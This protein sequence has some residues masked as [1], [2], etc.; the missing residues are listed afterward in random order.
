VIPVSPRVEASASLGT[1]E[2]LRILLVDD[3]ENDVLRV[4]GMLQDITG[5][6][7]DLRWLASH[8]EASAA[9]GLKEHD[10][11]F[12]DYPMGRGAG[13][14]LLREAVET[15]GDVPVIVLA[16]H[17]DDELVVAATEAGATACLLKERLDPKQLERTVRH[18][19]AR[20]RSGDRFPDPATRDSLTGLLNRL[21]LNDR[22]ARA[23]TYAARFGHRLA[24]LFLDLDNF[25][26]VNDAHGREA[27][28][29]LLQHVAKRLSRCVRLTDS[30]ARQAE[31]D[32][33]MG[34][35]G[36]DEFIL[37]LTNIDQIE[38]V[39]MV[40]NR[41]LREIGKVVSDLTPPVETSASIG[42]SIYPDHGEEAQAL[43]DCADTALFHAKADGKG[44]YRLY[45]PE[46]VEHTR[47]RLGLR[48]AL[49]Q[50]ELTLGY[51]PA[52]TLNER[53]LIALE[54]LPTW[55]HSQQGVIE[56][57]RLRCLAAQT[58]LVNVLDSWVLR[59][60][61]DQARRWIAAGLAPVPLVAPLDAQSLSPGPVRELRSAIEE[62]GTRSLQVAVAARLLDRPGGPY[63]PELLA[64]LRVGLVLDDFGSGPFA[65][66]TLVQLPLKMIWVSP[67]LVED[68]TS[69]AEDRS[70]IRGAVALAHA[71]GCQVVARGVETDAQLN[72]MLELGCDGGQG[73]LLGPPLTADEAAARLRR[74][75]DG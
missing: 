24:V 41:I 48:R 26:Q 7:V 31:F 9:F 28:D 14:E 61:A 56:S 38:G 6:Q 21:H 75:S 39:V 51:L 47:D 64:E 33:T 45:Q 74:A 16:D 19:L 55:A 58:G 10:L 42:I 43:I 71:L 36:G 1:M 4:R 59:A 67:R 22:L 35:L 37:L 52:V 63:L 2:T 17:A 15:G 20:K 69:S 13:L 66:R 11:C 49:A 68:A 34:R 54:P 65:I 27:G 32:A 30:V 25:G 8:R 5:I 29:R 53:E 23:M 73:P 44:T 60:A 70:T 72:A 12:L 40:A 50:S 57:G 18:A 62:A 3:N 46:M